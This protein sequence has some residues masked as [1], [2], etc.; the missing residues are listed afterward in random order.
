MPTT[1]SETQAQTEKELLRVFKEKL[2]QH[3]HP[4]AVG[5]FCTTSLQEKD[6]EEVKRKEETAGLQA[7]AD[8]L[9]EKLLQ[10]NNPGW[11]PEF[12]QALRQSG[13]EH[14]AEDLCP[15]ETAAPADSSPYRQLL[16]I[17]PDLT[18]T[19]VVADLLPYLPCLMQEDKE[20]IEQTR[21]T[22]GNTRAADVLLEK[23]VRCGP[24]WFSELCKALK[25]TGD[26]KSLDLLLDRRGADQDPT[27][28]NLSSLFRS[29][30]ISGPSPANE[31][32]QP[33]DASAMKAA[34]LDDPNLDEGYEEDAEDVSVR[35]TFAIGADGSFPMRD[36]QLELA[37]DVL[38]GENNVICSPTNS[39]KTRVA[40]YICKDH[41]EKNPDGKVLV[42]VNKVH[43][44]EQHFQSQFKPL[45]PES[46][47][48]KLGTI[49]GE[50]YS[51]AEEEHI[52]FK[53]LVEQKS[54]IILTA[55]ILENHL[56][57]DDEEKVELSDFSLMIFDECHH[58]KKEN[59]YNKI[60]GR[61]ILQKFRQPHLPLPQIVG[62][63]ASPGVGGAR[64][65]VQAVSHILQILANLNASKIKTAEKHAGELKK[66]VG[67][68]K[69]EC[70]ITN[71]RHQDPF[72]DELKKMMR[73][74]HRMIDMEGPGER[75]P[76]ADFGTQMYEQWVVEMEKQGGIEC[77]R[78]VQTC[79]DHLRKYSDALV[80]NDTLRMS[81]AFQYL[82]EFY[83][84]ESERQEGF[85]DTDR[86][87]TSIFS[88]SF[89]R[90]ERLTKMSQYENTN[91]EALKEKLKQE[92]ESKEGARGILYTKT[93]QSTAFLLSW[94]RNTPELNNLLKADQ[95]TGTGTGSISKNNHMTPIKQR[96]VIRKFREGELNLLIATTVAE[97]GLDIKECNFVI[98][99][100]LVTNEIAM[101]QASGRA[102]AEDSTYML[103]AGG[104]TGAGQREENNMYKVQMMHRAIK[105]IQD[106]PADLY[107][108][109]IQKR[110][111]AICSELRA[112][113]NPAIK[114]R[115]QAAASGTFLHCKKCNQKACDAAELR[116]IEGAH[117]V[118]PDP[119]FLRTVGKADEAEEPLQELQERSRLG[120]V[121]CR[122]G[123][124][125]CS[126]CE[127]DWGMLMLHKGMILPCL[128]VKNFALRKQGLPARRPKKWKD[129]GVAVAEFD[130]AQDI[131]LGEVAMDT[132]DDDL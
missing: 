127:Q 102:R 97:E 35:G 116:L 87:L 76:P 118:H 11:F 65:H 29:L 55:Q 27:D 114:A 77:R 103:V 10:Q 120:S 25:N 108:Q 30:S 1:E 121:G 9:L 128:S 67:Q 31:E 57:R 45:L 64:T 37:E 73:Q 18:Q 12:V 24:E 69:R 38:K 113:N 78:C 110:Q 44:V 17:V 33:A 125:K 91:L 8:L 15:T 42:M 93:R 51:S 98:R 123:S 7:A 32:V 104:K 71:E 60:M 122:I 89:F 49:S 70:H 34:M 117:H 119:G 47:Q 41:L 68:P 79:A 23:I 66:V 36:Y 20:Q 129:S 53:Q 61:V 13:S 46:F 107:D 86:K 100:G 90:L 84:K 4:T 92:C 62:F 80:I 26:E 81:D 5:R 22:S 131:E 115:K 59:V 101:M 99:Y 74:I 48:S 19:I 130:Y 16:R 82:K 40:V 43:L 109:E 96:E 106:M 6:Q 94:I 111:R 52:S 95:L 39:G 56:N 54:L 132:S 124:V 58:T 126:K 2:V 50:N 14:V 85:D 105:Y 83:A 63:T 28:E 112:R 3:I 75:R 21:K 72:G 88:E